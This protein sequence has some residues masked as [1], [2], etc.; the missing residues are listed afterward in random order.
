MKAT[1]RPSMI[2]IPQ[3]PQRMSPSGPHRQR[4]QNVKGLTTSKH[5]TFIFQKKKKKRQGHAPIFLHQADTVTV[6][7]LVDVHLAMVEEEECSGQD[8]GMTSWLA[9]GLKIEEAQ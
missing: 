8:I 7:A 9:S 3:P 4:M 6:L 5:L 1:L 2:Q